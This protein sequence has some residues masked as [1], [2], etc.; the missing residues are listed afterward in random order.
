MST[1][2]RFDPKR[3]ATPF[4]G[5]T[6]RP[7]RSVAVEILAADG[8]CVFVLTGPL[9]GAFFSVASEPLSIG[10]DARCGLSLDDVAASRFHAEISVDAKGARL[11]DL[12]S[13]NGTYLNGIV[14]GASRE[15]VQGDRFRVGDTELI[16]VDPSEILLEDR[17]DEPGGEDRRSSARVSSVVFYSSGRIEGRGIPYDV[18]PTGARILDASATVSIGSVVALLPEAIEE[19][20]TSPVRGTVVRRDAS[21]FAVC[22]DPPDASL[23]AALTGQRRC[24]RPNPASD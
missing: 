13:T 9:R 6:P 15:L 12:D 19:D 8:P 1:H 2:E 23:V 7:A 4:L 17:I 24:D 3:D 14:R 22:F 20:S 11:R 10:R 16:F 5:D 21:G 18:S